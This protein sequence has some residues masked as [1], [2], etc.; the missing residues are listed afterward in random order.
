MTDR[1][2]VVKVATGEIGE[3]VTEVSGA[4]IVRWEDGT[5]SQ[6][7]ISRTDVQPFELPMSAPGEAAPP[8]VKLD[9][10]T[11]KPVSPALGLAALARAVFGTPPLPG[12]DDSQKSGLD[13]E[14]ELRRHQLDYF[15]SFDARYD[16]ETT[17][18]ETML[19]LTRDMAS[20]SSRQTAALETIARALEALASK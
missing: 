8:D 4:L 14:R 20:D 5:Q 13:I 17:W 11:S 9:G 2:R 18:R 3:V 15:A 12:N 10:Q 6:H 1:K 16:R 7:V 19:E